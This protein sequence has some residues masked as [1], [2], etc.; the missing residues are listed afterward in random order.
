MAHPGRSGTT[1]EALLAP[2]FRPTIMRPAAL[3]LCAA[4]VAAAAVDAAPSASSRSRP[5]NVVVILTDDQGWGDVGYNCRNASVCPRT[6]NIDRLA[7]GP[8]S[9]LFHRFYSGA[10]VCSPTRA[11]VLTGRN[12]YRGCVKSALPCDHMASGAA[13][14]S[15]GPGLSHAEFTIAEAAAKAGLPSIHLGKWP[16]LPTIP[17]WCPVSHR[18]SRHATLHQRWQQPSPFLLGPLWPSL[19]DR[20]PSPV[21]AQAPG[22]PVEQER[23]TGRAALLPDRPR[24][25]ALVLLAGAAADVDA[26]LR[27]L[28]ARGLAPAAAAARLRPLDR[29]P[30]VQA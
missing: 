15:Q 25:H 11:S 12:N 27:L 26:Q 19:A 18:S 28:P 23:P 3:A 9:V 7:T 10:A 2:T 17:P 21:H 4:V 14:C 29:R 1:R 30:E 6:P 22:R 24:L 16:V 5:P 13:N 20:T 8:H